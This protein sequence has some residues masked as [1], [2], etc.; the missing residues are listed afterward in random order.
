MNDSLLPQCKGHEWE[1]ERIKLY[2]WLALTSLCPFSALDSSGLPLQFKRS[3]LLFCLMSSPVTLHV[4]MGEKHK[5]P[6]NPKAH[7]KSF[8]KITVRQ[9]NWEF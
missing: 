2:L 4:G 6:Y 7:T 1:R 9:K 3:C 8:T 5:I